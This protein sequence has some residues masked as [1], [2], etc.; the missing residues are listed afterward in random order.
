MFPVFA[1]YGENANCE[2]CAEGHK[3][4]IL[5]LGA[6]CISKVNGAWRGGRTGREFVF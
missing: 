3:I 6:L 1:N 4:G 2:H 5:G